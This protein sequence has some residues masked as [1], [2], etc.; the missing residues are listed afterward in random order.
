MKYKNNKIG[1]LIYTCRKLLKIIRGEADVGPIEL[2]RIVVGLENF[3]DEIERKDRKSN[4][5]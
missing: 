1:F 4:K 2:V 3:L 5:Q